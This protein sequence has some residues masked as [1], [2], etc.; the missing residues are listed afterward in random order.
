MLGG[1]RELCPNF[2]ILE[3][4]GSGRPVDQWGLHHARIGNNGDPNSKI[5]GFLDIVRRFGS[6]FDY[7]MLKFCYVD[8]TV[9]SNISELFQ[10]YKSLAESLGPVNDMPTI[11]HCT[12]P[13]RTVSV[14]VRSAIRLV[15]RRPV[16]ALSDNAARDEFSELL[17]Q[18]YG[19]TNR[20]FD[21]AH[22]QSTR[23]DGSIHYCRQAEMRIPTMIPSLS[24]DGGH[25]NDLG[26]AL[27]GTQFLRFLDEL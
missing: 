22:I 27:V 18:E 1:V 15:L 23:P 12:V 2:P 16:Q 8:V 9:Q 5:D 20:L 19:Q 21:L 6:S 13:V 14:G 25:L 10:S 11:L 3:Y 17:R 7:V 24:D 4:R 26:K